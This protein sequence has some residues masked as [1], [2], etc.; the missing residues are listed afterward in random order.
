MYNDIH[1]STDGSILIH[2]CMVGRY[3]KQDVWKEN[4]G[5][6]DKNGVGIV[7]FFYHGFFI[8]GE[9]SLNNYSR[10]DLKHYVT[11]HWQ[12]LLKAYHSMGDKEA[13]ERIAQ[14]KK[15]NKTLKF[16]YGYCHL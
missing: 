3:V 10:K 11:E 2:Q 4:G 13:E 15:D 14:A 1:M 8:T 12:E 5:R 6:T 9:A 7:P 16:R